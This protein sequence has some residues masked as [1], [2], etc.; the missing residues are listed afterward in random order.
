MSKKN[1]DPT[2]S[3]LARHFAWKERIKKEQNSV[4]S[5][6]QKCVSMGILKNLPLKDEEVMDLTPTSKANP[7]KLLQKL[8][9]T[10]NENLV[11]PT[12]HNSTQDQSP[13]L[14]LGPR[15]Y[16]ME[17]FNEAKDIVLPNI[18]TRKSSNETVPYSEYIIGAR[19]M[20]KKEAPLINY[21]SSFDSYKPQKKQ[22]YGGEKQTYMVGTINLKQSTFTYLPLEKQASQKITFMPTKPKV[23]EMY[24]SSKY[25]TH[26]RKSL[27]D[28]KVDNKTA[29]TFN[30]LFENNTPKQLQ[31]SLPPKLLNLKETRRSLDAGAQEISPTLANE[32]SP[33]KFILTLT[34]YSNKAN[35]FN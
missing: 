5:S 32:H 33:S 35:S 9:D 1:M 27:A 3:N 23:D 19:S 26:L 7:Y 12:A 10:Q 29:N 6:L 4:Y 17:D 31:E 25:G 13:V 34:L 21:R 2:A 24:Y 22:Y 11:S 30:T 15:R 14:K 8:K 28:L 16:S 18:K 20:V